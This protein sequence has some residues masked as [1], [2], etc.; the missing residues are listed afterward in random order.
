[1]T[2]VIHQ[3]PLDAFLN[4]VSALDRRLA[5]GMHRLLP[6]W[7]N[8]SLNQSPGISQQVILGLAKF[9]NLDLNTVVNPHATLRFNDSVRKYKHAANKS[10]EQLHA[11]TAVVHGIS[12]LTAAAVLSVI[13]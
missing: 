2:T 8:D 3:K 7:W 5:D 11:A 6:E 9:A 1:M 12:K 10:V 4:R 13:A